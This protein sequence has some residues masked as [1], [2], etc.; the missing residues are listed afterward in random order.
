MNFLIKNIAWADGDIY[1]TCDVRIG[2]GK[3]SEIGKL[4]PLKEELT[5]DGTN[6]FLYPGFIN[7]HDHLEMNLYPHMGTPLYK[8]YT[9]WANDIY[10]PKESPVRE[11]ER[12]DI[13]DRLFWGGIKNLIS[14]AI[15]VVHHNPWHRILSKE[16]FPVE[17]VQTS[18]AHSLAFEKNV[19]KKFPKKKTLTFVIHAGEGVDEFASTEI[20]KLH[21]LNL[22]QKNT[23]LIHAIALDE[24]NIRLIENA[25]SSIIWCPSSNL[26]MFNRTSPINLIKDKISVALGTDSTMTGTSTLLDEMRT[27]KNTGLA[28]SREIFEMVTSTPASI[29]NI[30]APRIK[31]GNRANLWISP[32]IKS[33]YYENIFSIT[34]SDIKGVFV[35][36]DLRLCDHELSGIS[37]AKYSFSIS[38]KQ[39]YSVYNVNSL[40]KKFEL[41]LAHLPKN[42]LWQML[43]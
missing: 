28:T 1:N 5:L 30:E 38:G 7:S 3:I 13:K 37:S 17:V 19:L 14:G 21:E 24:K 42:P 41:R 36:G 20:S 12:L 25:K 31:I 23:S 15:T 16:K 34:A 35:Q 11:I 2:K 6:C 32:I 9:E 4:T 18:W 8:N 27:A 10:K 33:D 29:F 26:F 40:K 43:D 39:K 22:L